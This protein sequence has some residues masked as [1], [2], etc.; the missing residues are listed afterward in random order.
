MTANKVSIA[1]WWWLLVL[2]YACAAG[3]SGMTPHPVRTSVAVLDYEDLS[4]MNAANL[5]LAELLTGKAIETI[6][7]AGRYDVVE[8]QRLAMV[9][10]ELNLGSSM[11]ADRQTQLKLGEITGA[12]L[13]VFGCYQ[14][15]DDQ[16]RLDARLVDVQSGRVIKAVSHEA[17]Q[18]NLPGWLDAVAK[19]TTALFQK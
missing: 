19:S 14:V 4:P 17:D 18:N 3:P 10:E 2:V 1:K 16:L 9:L 15:I 8:R 7:E 12:R 13:M 11:V 5:D 6:E